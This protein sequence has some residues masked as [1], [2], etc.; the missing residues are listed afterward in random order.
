MKKKIFIALSA[1]LLGVPALF[2]AG[3]DSEK[4]LLLMKDAI[5]KSSDKK[6][7]EAIKILNKAYKLDPD[8]GKILYNRGVVYFQSG[9]DTRAW[10]DF[11]QACEMGNDGAC[12]AVGR[13]SSK[14]VKTKE[15]DYAELMQAAQQAQTKGQYKDAADIYSKAAAV[16]PKSEEPYFKRGIIR[17]HNLNDLSGAIDDFDVVLKRSRDNVAA[18]FERAAAYAAT[19]K[20]GKAIKDYSS[21]LDLDKD[22]YD[23]LLARADL[24]SVD[25]NFNKALKDYEAA[26]ILKPSEIYLFKSV[27]KCRMSLKKTKPAMDA[28]AKACAMKDTESCVYAKALQAQYKKESRGEVDRY[29]QKA[30]KL[31]SKQ[32]YKEELA[33]LNEAIAAFPEAA[34][35][36]LA[37]GQLYLGGLKNADKSRDSALLDFNGAVALEPYYAPAYSARAQVFVL[38]EDDNK[39]IADLQ[40]AV[41]LS[42][43]DWKSY[44]IMGGLYS[45]K[46]RR[47]DSVDAFEKCLSINAADDAAAYG[48]AAEYKKTGDLDKAKDYYKKA[49]DLKLDAACQAYNSMQ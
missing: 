9:E 26:L 11:K 15:I 40:Q 23:A 1:A 22:N 44:E 30:A 31:D 28:Y 20:T 3:A 19:D 25:G 10:R 18:Y 17:A 12:E 8:N 27:G 39:A 13:M 33:I 6:Y 4:A 35:L 29:L 14:Q 2:A 42:P 7:D 46:G 36:V 37:R 41:A 24:Y 38:T 49:C 47:R 48:L 21:V 43:G 32:A 45:K 16:A 34:D 5:G